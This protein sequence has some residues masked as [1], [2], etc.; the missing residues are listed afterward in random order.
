MTLLLKFTSPH[1]KTANC[2]FK[3]MSLNQNSTKTF[4]FILVQHI[5]FSFSVVDLSQRMIQTI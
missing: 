4:L 5:Y 1:Q 2:L 3:K